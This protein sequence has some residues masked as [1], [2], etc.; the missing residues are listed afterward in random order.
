MNDTIDFSVIRGG[1]ANLDASVSHAASGADRPK[2]AEMFTPERHAGALDPNVTVVLGAR[3][4]GKSFWAGVLGDDETR[5]AAAEAYPRIGLKN[6]IVKFGYTGLLADGSIS[7]ST[8]DKQVPLGKERALGLQL[9]RCV[10]LR[11]IQSDL[12]SGGQSTIGEMMSHYSDPEV[13]ER[14]F[15]IA[16][17]Q[18]EKLNKNILVLFDALDSMAFDWERLRGLTDALL[19]VAWSTR[20]YRSVKIKLFLRPDQ[21][22][23]MGLKFTEVPKLIAGA[24]NL[25]WTGTDLYGMLFTRLSGI[26]DHDFQNQLN[27]LFAE[28]G[29]ASPP[30]TLGLRRTWPLVYDQYLQSRV[31]IRL[32]GPYMGRGHKKGKTYDWPLRHLSDGHEEVTPRS[33]LTLMIEAARNSPGATDLAMTAEGIRH[34]LRE[35]SKVRVNQLD[36]EFPWIKR[37]LAP[38]ARLQVPC[39]NQQI[40]DRWRETGTL[41]SI[42]KRVNN[43]ELLAPFDPNS[44]RTHEDMLIE[45]LVNIGVLMVRNDGRF[46]MPDLFR[47]AARLLK[48]GGVAPV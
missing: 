12:S 31:F 34:G 33:F 26:Q 20:G 17:K 47:V 19:E 27:R 30:Q 24:T 29:V 39:A 13:W 6:L 21:L 15:E 4:A 5:L 11:A 38:L 32:A 22:S 28:E 40:I 46:D 10:I 42:M 44:S 23:F 1:L 35:A 45:T 36:L 41:E 37:V 8:I 14:D 7:S 3:G 16:N 2:V 18:L 25:T 9:W 43:G 48:K